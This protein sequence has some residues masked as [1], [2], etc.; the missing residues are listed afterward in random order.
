VTIDGTLSGAAPGH[1]RVVLQGQPASGGG[2]VMRASAVSLGPT[3]RPDLYQGSV[4]A[5][6]GSQLQLAVAVPGGASVPIGVQLHLDGSSIVTGT[7]TGG[8]TVSDGGN[9]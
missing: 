7:V 6:A 9:D 8:T 1:L 3:T 2:L 4:R 5:L